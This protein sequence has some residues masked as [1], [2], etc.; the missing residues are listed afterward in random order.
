MDAAAE[1]MDEAEERIDL[2]KLG[3]EITIPNP[4]TSAETPKGEEE[5]CDCCGCRCD[6]DNGGSGDQKPLVAEEDTFSPRLLTAATNESIA[7]LE[8]DDPSQGKLEG[9]LL[10]HPLDVSE[11][12]YYDEDIPEHTIPSSFRRQQGIPTSPDEQ[13]QQQQLGYDAVDDDVFNP[14]EL[15]SRAQLGYDDEPSVLSAAAAA[16]L[17]QGRPIRSRRA[18]AVST[19]RQSMSSHR[20]ST[21]SSATTSNSSFWREEEEWERV[22]SC[23]VPPPPPTPPPFQRSQTSNSHQ[24]TRRLS[25]MSQR[26]SLQ[27]SVGHASTTNRTMRRLS[28]GKTPQRL[29]MPGQH[30]NDDAKRTMIT[31]RSDHHH[32]QQ[33]HH[34][35]SHYKALQDLAAAASD[36]LDS[37]SRLPSRVSLE[38]DNDDGSTIQEKSRVPRRVS[39][40][41]STGSIGGQSSS[42]FRN[43]NRRNSGG[44]MPRRVSLEFQQSCVS[45]GR[46]GGD[47]EDSFFSPPMLQRRGSLDF[48]VR[49]SCLPRRQSKPNPEDCTSSHK[50]YQRRASTG[51]GWLASS[52]SATTK[53]SA[54]T[55]FSSGSSRSNTRMIYDRCPPPP[56][57]S[58]Q[59]HEDNVE[60]TPEGEPLMDSSTRTTS[61]RRSLARGIP[62]K[63]I[64]S[65]KTATTT[66][67][68]LLAVASRRHPDA[69]VGRS[70]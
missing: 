20:R 47:E 58:P 11:L 10:R 38:Y 22:N 16:A 55:R 42:S 33:Q 70:A 64:G 45:P 12:G 57:H 52:S 62:R 25:M 49:T 59:P 51:A 65:M 48:S 2:S 50:K 6:D 61:S 15:P 30:D 40:Q 9:T 29:S 23:A 39:L 68:E 46:G 28:I 63:Q 34:N 19:R 54:F 14:A 1:R 31:S 41:F 53:G 27:G 8:E 18:S 67:M 66:A 17:S 3:F 35:N 4:S 43:N 21:A 36:L 37:R 56:H 13:Q 7:H 26:S 44:R 69:Q 32:H 5:G 24:M 60:E